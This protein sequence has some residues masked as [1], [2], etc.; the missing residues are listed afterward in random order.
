M[1]V[2]PGAAVDPAAADPAV[3]ADLVARARATG[4]RPVLLVDGGSGAG[5]STLAGPL[6]AA[7]HAQLVRLDD[8]YPGWD[9]LEAASRAVVTD[10][11]RPERPGWR[12]WD[13][14][15]ERPAGWHPL[16]PRAALVVE[17]SGALSRAARERADLAIWIDCRPEE[18]RRRALARDGD[19]YAP[20][21][22]RWAAQEA[23]F[24]ARERPDL[25]ADVVLA[26]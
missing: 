22:L 24:F 4:G 8:L 16:D 15:R 2:E 3:L 19:R 6:A 17:G 18:R 21:W 5:K 10:V 1:H 13:W 25:L 23:A 7:L 9:G 12:G 26:G 14:A 11:L 20:H